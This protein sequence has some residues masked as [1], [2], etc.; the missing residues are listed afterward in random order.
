MGRSISRGI[1]L[2]EL[3]GNAVATTFGVASDV[4]DYLAEATAPRQ[5]QTS[6][7]EEEVGNEV[8]EIASSSDDEPTFRRERSRSKDE[9]DVGHRLEGERVEAEVAHLIEAIHQKRKN[10]F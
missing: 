3:T 8:E 9:E 4:A 1:R 10:N 7:E 6:E 2:A 5:H